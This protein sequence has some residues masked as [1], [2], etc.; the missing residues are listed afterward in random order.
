MK[1]AATF[2][3][4][5]ASLGS[6]P[7]DGLPEVA[8]IGRSNVGKSSLINALA[9]RR[10]L[11]KTSAT[12]GKTRTLNY[13]LV[14][15]KFYLVDM[16]GYG[17]AKQAKSERMDWARLSERYFLERREL[18]MTGVLIDARHPNLESDALILE[19]FR[20][21][22][23]PNFVVLTKADK[24]RQ[25][26]IAKHVRI[27]EELQPGATIFITSSPESR[28]IA[29]LRKFIVETAAERDF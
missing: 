11:A 13:Y 21:H 17:Y 24:A 9:E 4:S 29:E 26:E 25:Q 18:R 15:G 3:S 5:F 23:I 2:I 28:G 14:N 8:L 19:W 6:L 22:K 27:I 20:E 10:N 16:P 1:F 7:K 12:P